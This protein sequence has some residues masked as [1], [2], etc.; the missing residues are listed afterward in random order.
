MQVLP[1]NVGWHPGLSGAF[2]IMEFA[3]FP[4]I[5]YRETLTGDTPV[6][7]APDVGHY[8]LAFDHL[9]AAALSP[10]E[11]QKVAAVVTRKLRKEQH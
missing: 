9:R 1:S 11:S 6:E 3:E 8:T 7:A 5:A 10:V 4:T 2:T